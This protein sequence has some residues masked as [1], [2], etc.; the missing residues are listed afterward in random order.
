MTGL[1]VGIVGA[2]PG[3]LALALALHH[4]GITDV[5][6]YEQSDTIERIGAG[7]Q[8]SPNAT[9]VLGALGL[10]EPLAAI[11]F[12]PQ[13]VQFRAWRSGY[14]IATR[15]LGGFSEA[16]YGAP[17][18]HIHRGDLQAL[19]FEQVR[20]LDIPVRTGHT[21]ATLRQDTDG[22]S[23]A[24]ACGRTARHGV[25]VGCDGIRSV[26]R[27]QLF[28]A[29]RPRFTGHLAWR[30]LVPAERLP[31]DLVPPT[32]TAWLG[33]RKHFV[34]YYVRGGAL[35]NFVGVIEDDRWQSDSWREPGDP[36]ELAR[37]FR[38][39]HPSIRRIIEASG[40]VFRWALHDH[41]PLPAWTAGRATLLGDACH[42]M[43]PYLAQGAAMAIEDAWVLA[44]ML[45]HWE[46][47]PTEGLV[48][49]ERYRRPRTARVQAGSRAQGETF[50]LS[51]RWR[52]VGRNLKLGLGSRY[53]PEI[54]MAQFDWL[55]GYD[56]VKGFD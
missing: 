4:A 45:E 15:P 18:Y 28:G 50:H 25:A 38:D 11:G 33:P 42:P 24:F 32:V 2:G 43:L 5:T 7:I 41:A 30:G 48:Q 52:I 27:A 49:Y 44:R 46:D 35:V 29:T 51:D 53:L 54:A 1:S 47:E 6:V 36:A 55:H 26:V 39:W 12:Y 40:D 13:A 34:H 9:R 10:R 21:L 23:L 16:R 14:L 3:G 20:A 8:L 22:V 31:A 19:L 17:Y 37:D 56:C